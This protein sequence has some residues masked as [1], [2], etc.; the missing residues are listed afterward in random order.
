MNIAV[1]IWGLL[2]SSVVT[3]GILTGEWGQLF[4]QIVRAGADLPTNYRATRLFLAAAF[5]SYFGS[6]YSWF[7]IDHET[8]IFIALWVP[9]ILA[10]GVLLNVAPG[11]G[12]REGV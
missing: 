1:L 11:S 5:L 12:K 8:G 4:S 7:L 3:S 2:V 10:L 9:S 6:V